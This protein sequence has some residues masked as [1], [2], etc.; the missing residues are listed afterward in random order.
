MI[1]TAT[2]WHRWRRRRESGRQASNI[3]VVESADVILLAVKPNVMGLVLGGDWGRLGAR[4]LLLSIAAGIDL[5][6]IES[7]LSA[8]VP[9]IRAMPNTP[10]L[11]GK[12]RLP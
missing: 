1:W 11:V 12:E 6:F 8:D 9:V 5:T 4:Q 3:D 7:R 2:A 10:C